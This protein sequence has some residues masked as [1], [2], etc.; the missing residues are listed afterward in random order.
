M[1]L[2][3][4]FRRA[5]AVVF[6]RPFASTVIAF[7]ML[8]TSACGGGSGKASAGLGEASRGESGSAR[9]IYK[10]TTHVI[11]LAAARKMI[12]GVSTNGAGLLLDGANRDAQSIGAGDTLVIKELAARKIIGTKTLTDGSIIALTQ[13]AS[14]LDAVEEAHIVVSEPV[15]FGEMTHANS[16]GPRHWLGDF[17]VPSANAQGAEQII[18]SS[19]EHAG[20]KDALGNVVSGVKGALID[21]WTVDFQATPSKDRVTL[22]IILTKEVAGFRAVIN[23][24]GYL[25]NFDMDGD[26]DIEKGAYE[27]LQTGFKNVNGVMNFKWEVATEGPGVHTGDDRIKLPAAIEV[28]LYKALDGF[29][30]FLELSSALI[31]KPALSGGREYSRGSFRITY[32]GYQNFTAK[33]GNI[34]ADGKVTG[35]IEFLEAQNISPTAPMGMVVAFAAPRIELTFGVSKIFDFGDMKD[36]AGKVDAATDFLAKELMTPEQ[37][38]AFKASPAG[39]IGLSKAIDN[40]LKSDAAAYF[41][42]VASAGMSNTGMSVVTPCTRHDIHL[43]AKVGVSAEVFGQDVGR[44]EKEVYT[45]DFTRIDPPGTDLCEAVGT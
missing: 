39:Q 34:D 6:A 41:E 43:L 17:L 8:A 16:A 30:L 9:V 29:P 42:F 32:D 35:D 1:S 38:A 4:R 22:A 20:A 21:G 5:G 13:Q 23:G 33:K 45:K 28:P 27:K 12:L 14:L 18:S 44:A 36:A 19:A 10:S 11:S 24:D 15:R 3:Y 37:Y 7:S 31:I 25:K 26:I 2:L 40:A